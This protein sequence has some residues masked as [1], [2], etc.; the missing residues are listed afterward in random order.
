[1]RE[2]LLASVIVLVAAAAILFF[3][4]G[5]S[6]AN[7]DLDGL[8]APPPQPEGLY[9]AAERVAG[10]AGG[11]V[12]I[13]TPEPIIITGTGGGPTPN[14]A[15]FGTNVDIAP[16]ANNQAYPQVAVST[17]V[18]RI[19]VAFQNYTGASWDIYVKWS[20]D[21]GVTWSQYAVATDAW[22]EMFPSINVH[23]QSGTDHVNVFYS[24][25]NN[26]DQVCWYHSDDG[27]TWSN[28]CVTPTF[29][30]GLDPRNFRYS[31]QSSYGQHSYVAFDAQDG[32][33][34][35]VYTLFWMYSDD[36]FHT[37]NPANWGATMF[38]GSFHPT[39]QWT[40]PQIMV[41][42]SLYQ[43]D[44]SDFFF[45]ACAFFA[46]EHSNPAGSFSGSWDG[47]A[48]VAF[49]DPTPDGDPSCQSNY[50][51]Y[52]SQ[53]LFGGSLLNVPDYDPDLV[54]LGGNNGAAY[55]F[56]FNDTDAAS[57]L[58]RYMNDGFLYLE[59]MGYEAGSDIRYPALFSANGL[60]LASF[61]RDDIVANFVYSTD[62][63]DT[64]STE[65]KVSDNGGTA[66]PGWRSITVAYSDRVHVL[67]MDNR[68][69]D[70]DIFYAT[71]SGW[72][73]YRITRSPEVGQVT[74]NG[75]A[76]DV[77]KIF[78]WQTGN[79][80]DVSTPAVEVDPID[81]DIR[82]VFAS[83]SDLGA[84]SHTVTVGTSD[85]VL[86]A[87]YDLQFYLRVST[88]FG[89]ISCIPAS[90][91]GWYDQGT[92]I[93][94]TLTL[95]PN[96]ADTQYL[97]N[98]WISSG[99]LGCYDGSN[100]P[101]VVTM[102]GPCTE[103]ALVNRLFLLAVTSLYGTPSGGG[104]YSEGATAAFS[105]NSPVAGPPGVRYAF[106]L[107][108]GTGNGT[109]YS[110]TQNPGSVVMDGPITETALWNT[111][112]QLTMTA[113]AGTTVP[114]TSWH[115]QNRVVQ[116]LALPPA[117][118]PGER[119]IFLGWTG[120]S[121]SANNPENITMDA[122]KGYTSNW[123]HQWYLG[124][125]TNV[126]TISCAPGPCGWYNQATAVQ[127][128]A[129]PPAAGAGARYLFLGWT[130]TG[131]GSFTGITNPAGVTMNGF[132]FEAAR[133]RHEYQLTISANFGSVTPPTGS[134]IED[135]V[136][137]Q[138]TATPP[139]STATERY[140]NLAWGG[141][142][143]G[144][145]IGPA[146]P[147]T[148]TMNG[149]IT[150][151]ATWVHEFYLDVRMDFGVFVCLPAGSPGP[152]G[153]YADG[154]SV[155][156]QATPPAS[157]VGEQYVWQGW[158]GTGAPSYSGMNNPATVVVS[159]GI[160]EE[161]SF[162][163][164]F[165]VILTANTAGV[166]LIPPNGWYEAGS[167]LT[168]SSGAPST[169]PGERYTFTGWVGTPT[170]TGNPVTVTLDGAK[171]YVAQWV[172]E[173]LLLAGQNF[174]SVSCTPAPCGWYAAGT[175]VTLG[176]TSPGSGSGERYTWVGWTGSGSGSYTGP[177]AGPTVTMNAPLVDVAEWT[178]EFQLTVT[179]AYGNP[180][181]TGW[182]SEGQTAV[183]SVTTPFSSGAGTRRVLVAW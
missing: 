4:S 96:T 117:V 101:A 135:G 65:Q 36:A 161:G 19:Y 138:I 149:P 5:N 121:V 73:F 75:S 111:E 158:T 106:F 22:N 162:R 42:A 77:P 13:V 140:A 148:I 93:A 32:G 57:L 95:P 144:S 126:G 64:W 122:P 51:F 83:W 69:G 87:F 145:Y 153:W 12:Q 43:F 108:A 33:A 72:H 131:T 17:S 11:L 20:D 78:L 60:V 18:G 89:T 67:W 21:G 104:W 37:S 116:I 9:G 46:L 157:G 164:Q 136:T 80:F 137:V 52:L 151:V 58:I 163:H 2:L 41:N 48:D 97:F 156:V 114:P 62:Y 167:S 128:T 107:W 31:S 54:D 70:S 7:P 90:C 169:L 173:Y 127:V 55:A 79:W 66:M 143:T 130:G 170:I 118:G 56:T 152:C 109:A 45:D 123:Q 6:A 30:G 35:N 74:V 139:M 14:D 26:V 25:D 181:G 176:A 102:N 154:T 71:L 24:Q 134:W 28:F 68:D 38:G 113:G 177:L 82:Y 112:F 100:N 15:P 39:D 180:Q 179:S 120:S 119:W 23:Y 29:G 165:Q 34:G 175:S 27:A 168:F 76:Y 53:R 146:N 86:T 85:L 3:T 8:A 115:V 110:G 150:Q 171:T 59:I 63:G 98:Q 50:Y 160:V 105:V 141:S 159:A 133:F 10:Q 84:V 99:G 142:G 49:V 183:A 44:L 124:S 16:H 155:S 91:P 178:H 1:R 103:S 94:I 172:H 166:S 40:R 81:P 182:Y 47:T 132:V 92:V 174:G 61:V 125:T 147:A 129:T 88:T